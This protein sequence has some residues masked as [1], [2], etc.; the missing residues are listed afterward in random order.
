MF[1]EGWVGEGIRLDQTISEDKNI[2]KYKQILRK[3]SYKNI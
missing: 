2:Q 1:E 3:S